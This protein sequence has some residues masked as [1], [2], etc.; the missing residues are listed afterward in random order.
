MRG[1]VEHGIDAP[2]RVTI[3]PDKKLVKCAICELPWYEDEPEAFQLEQQKQRQQNAP[4]PKTRAKKQTTGPALTAKSVIKEARRELR[5]RNRRIKQL[6]R[7]LRAEK[8][9]AT[10]L[11][12]VVDAADGGR[13]AVVRH[14]QKTG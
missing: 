12:R 11:Q 8:K 2:K 9:T 4:A 1:C 3:T 5:E 6:E 13:L 14:I 7:E 10:E